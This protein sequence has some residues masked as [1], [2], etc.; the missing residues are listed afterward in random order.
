MSERQHPKNSE[1][2]RD[3]VSFYVKDDLTVDMALIRL[4]CKKR[5]IP[6]GKFLIKSAVE[7]ISA[8]ESWKAELKEIAE[9]NSE[10]DESDSE[11]DQ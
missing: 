11:S 10:S 1:R 4:Y 6:I 8:D 3:Q 5:R 2:Y 7:K 9:N